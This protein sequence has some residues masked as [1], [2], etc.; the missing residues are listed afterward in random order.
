MALRHKYPYRS[1][2]TSIAFLE[3]TCF[4]DFPCWH[5]RENKVFAE[6]LRGFSVKAKSLTKKEK[7]AL[8]RVAW[9]NNDKWRTPHL[10][11]V[12]CEL[13]R[14][15]NALLGCSVLDWDT[16]DECREYK[17][18]IGRI[19]KSKLKGIRSFYGSLINKINSVASR[20]GLMDSFDEAYEFYT[21]D[22]YAD[23]SK[24]FALFSEATRDLEQAVFD[25]KGTDL[26][27]HYADDEEY[28]TKTT[29]GNPTTSIE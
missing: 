8:I 20:Y 13:L 6:A 18:V 2:E 17:K 9:N 16:A 26:E 29:S 3:D 25:K 19:S 1:E 4:P 10:S 24:N 5:Y 27:G 11:D 22:S 21:G 7:I 28:R 12:E 15:L 23:N 14:G